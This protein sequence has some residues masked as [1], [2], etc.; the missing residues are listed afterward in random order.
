MEIH[1]E[2]SMFNILQPGS[3]KYYQQSQKLGTAHCVKKSKFHVQ[4]LE[5]PAVPGLLTVFVVLISK[6]CSSEQGEDS[7]A[8]EFSSLSF[9][10]VAYIP[11][12]L[13][14]RSADLPHRDTLGR[15]QVFMR[16]SPLF[17]RSVLPLYCLFCV[18][19]YRKFLVTQRISL[20]FIT[21][22][23]SALLFPYKQ[24]FSVLSIISSC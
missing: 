19:N 4:I 14:D 9:I 1:R 24:P 7:L 22:V 12:Y 3:W 20:F 8:L 17:S 6:S 21:E 16:L 23:L 11:L 15:Q 2:M 13:L 5:G 10:Q 18:S